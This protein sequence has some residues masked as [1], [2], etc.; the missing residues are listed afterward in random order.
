MFVYAVKSE[1]FAFKWG[2]TLLPLTLRMES[3]ALKRD[4]HKASHQLAFK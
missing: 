2:D 1:A 3:L 4:F